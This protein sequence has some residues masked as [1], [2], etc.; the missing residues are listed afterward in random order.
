MIIFSFDC[1][2]KNLG[3]CCIEVNTNWS[4]QTEL[5]IQEFTQLY[6]NDDQDSIN[7]L[8]KIHILV[9]KT[10]T[11]VNSIFQIKYMN[12][13]DLAAEGKAKETKLTEIVKRLKYILFCLGNQLPKPDIVLIEYQ[14][15]ANDKS[16]GIC[17]Y[18][19]EYYLPIGG[20]DAT[21][22]YAMP[23]YPLYA[24][25]ISAELIS[26][27]KIYIVPPSLK[28]SYQIDPSIKGAYQTFI[29]KCNRSYDANKAH[30]I[31]NFVYFL[32]TRNLSHTIKN[33]PNKLDDI[34]DA[35]MQAYS[36]CKAEN[37]F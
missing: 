5:I 12:I 19:E 31:Y 22:T 10:D 17:R 33:I 20:T 32:Q 8:D 21:I 3:F 26:E 35:F 29:E 34:A 14:M 36:W 28:N 30:A 27:T 4:K 18:I 9:K 1:A 2:I 25:D 24:S 11:L 13:F 23:E 37:F 16:R 6:S 7:V 15:N